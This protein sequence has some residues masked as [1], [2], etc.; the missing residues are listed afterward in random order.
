M[1]EENKIEFLDEMKS[2]F[3]KSMITLFCTMI[4]MGITFYY[5]TKHNDSLQDYKILELQTGCAKSN[6]I[7]IQLQNIEKS[8][9]E[10]KNATNKK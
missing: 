10:L 3:A 7:K 6:E 5:T 8:I 1:S 9:D 4:M 2:W